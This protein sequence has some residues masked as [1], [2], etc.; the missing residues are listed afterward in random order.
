M[1]QIT[2]SRVSRDEVAT[3]QREVVMRGAA[4]NQ[5]EKGKIVRMRSQLREPQRM[6]GSRVKGSAEAQS[7]FAVRRI[8]VAVRCM[9]LQFASCS[10]QSQVTQVGAVAIQMLALRGNECLDF[11]EVRRGLYTEVYNYCP[12]DSEHIRDNL[13]DFLTSSCLR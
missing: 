13:L 12:S 2:A 10:L 11:V 1:G 5:G 6:Q 4:Q 9:Q 3:Q 7:Q 8:A